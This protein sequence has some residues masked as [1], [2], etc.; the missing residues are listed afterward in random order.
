MKKTRILGLICGM[1]FAATA[2]FAQPQ[3]QQ[4]QQ[5]G[6]RSDLVYTVNL[7]KAADLNLTKEILATQEFKDFF[8]SLTNKIDTDYVKASQAP[9]FPTKLA[10]VL[11][12]KVREAKGK[13]NISSKDV[14]ELLADQVELVQFDGF[15][16]KGYE[17][18]TKR[19]DSDLALPLIA[20]YHKFASITFV[21]KFPPA[22]LA[23]IIEYFET[24]KD[25]IT[26][27]IVEPD[28]ENFVVKFSYRGVQ[29]ADNPG[30]PNK[31]V[32][33]YAG[34]RKIEKLG[35]YAVVFSGDRDLIDRKLNQ[36]QNERSQGF[37]FGEN[38]P[39]KSLRIGKGVFDIVKQ[40]TQKKIDA[41][42]KNSKDALRMIEQ[43]ENVNISTRDFDGKT[44]TQIRVALATEEAATNLKDLAEAGKVL[45]TFA[46]GSENVDENGKVLLN[47]L[48][49]TEIKQNEKT[50]TA[51]INWSNAAFLEIV[52]K[53][54]KDADMEIAGK[55][56]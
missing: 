19:G 12:E 43:I 13:N 50:L 46:A 26:F 3:E 21:V 5:Q 51:R 15:I 17:N 54:L 35:T 42:D 16:K 23:G 36:L 39:A 52:K 24:V 11:L 37:L 22:E 2:G 7:A 56:K 29:S 48:L 33:I 6:Q 18:W 4:P 34:G 8:A 41:G 53:A 10:D 49:D 25:N 28:T 44:G 20:Y 40:E 47:L 30:D 32:S 31:W 38:A 27:E 45:L 9:I 55:D 1:I 14:L